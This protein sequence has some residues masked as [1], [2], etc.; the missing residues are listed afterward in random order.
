MVMPLGGLPWTPLLLAAAAAALNLADV[1]CGKPQAATKI[2]GGG[3]A[4]PGQFPW[5][6]SLQ[7]DGE[8]WCGGTLVNQWFVVTAAHCLK[9][10]KADRFSVLAG[11]HDLTTP[12]GKE[13]RL[14]VRAVAL[15]PDYRVGKFR[16]DLAVL[17]LAKPAVWGGRVQ[18]ACLPA[19]GQ[20]QAAV[21]RTATV[22]GWGWTAEV[23]DGGRRADRLRT[24]AVPVMAPEQCSAW[25]AAAGR[26]HRLQ[27]GQLCAGFKEGGRD[28][29][30]GD[31]GGPLLLE[32]RGRATL[33][34]VVS[35]GIG[36]GRPGL[37]GVY[38][39]VSHYS[40]WIKK[41]AS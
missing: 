1:P 21:N 7:L 41:M 2:V 3:G 29:C 16:H 12:E 24:V 13:Q 10:L 23:A 40:D 22:A 39:D 9:K 6:V 36:C 19:A 28:G 32:R 25:F 18:P 27:A 38:T 35:A 26:R 15:H 5:L 17:R 33:V 14:P 31:S 11:E 20:T 34:G 4:R 30:Q 8:P 37:P